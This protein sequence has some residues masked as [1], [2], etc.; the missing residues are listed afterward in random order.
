MIRRERHG[1][2]FAVAKSAGAFRRERQGFES[3]HRFE[4]HTRCDISDN[5]PK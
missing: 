4:T 1:N 2:N 3:A 5:Y